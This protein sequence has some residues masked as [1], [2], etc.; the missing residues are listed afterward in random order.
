[1]S[2]PTYISVQH[3]TTTIANDSATIRLIIITIIKL[4]IQVIV[5]GITDITDRG[6]QKNNFFVSE[7]VRGRA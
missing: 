4:Q 2:A 5:R 3:A 7:A 6:Q 1:M